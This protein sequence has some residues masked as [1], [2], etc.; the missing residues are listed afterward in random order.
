MTWFSVLLA[1]ESTHWLDA[2]IDALC[3]QAP[4]G[5]FFSFD[6][7]VRAL[8][9]LILVSLTC[10]GVGALVV[11]GRM[12]FFSDALAH[13]AFAG[14]SIGFVIFTVFLA[15]GQPE[16]DADNFWSWVSLIMLVFGMIVGFGIAW[17]REQTGLASDT[18]IG[19][20][21]AFSIGLAAMLRKLMQDRT[22][23]TLEDFLFG[24]PLTIRAGDLE[25]LAILAL[26]TLALL[27][28]TANSLLLSS[29]NTS[30]ALSRRVPIRLVS[31]V[32]IMLLA[33][34]VNL[35][36]RTVGV[37]LINALLVVPA[38]TAANLA[39]NL[40]QVFWLTL[41]FCLIACICG[42]VIA[43]E[44]GTRTYDPVTRGRVSLGIPGTIIFVSVGFFVV[45]AVLGSLWRDR[46]PG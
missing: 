25:Q 46:R 3:Q 30:L 29:F 43:W 5:S 39:R 35:C 10:G 38:A 34:I 4:P 37:L 27:W 42:Q 14:V 9:A 16:Q 11:G 26:V 13:S 7:N 23:F 17:V 32:F 41:L 6:F 8:L 31:Y 15:T 40:R 44:V 20:F 22:L 2:V 45:S 18:V 24:D 19:I 28:F 12:S 36:V 1:A 33:V 21:F